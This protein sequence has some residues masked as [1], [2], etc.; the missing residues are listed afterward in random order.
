M[1]DIGDSSSVKR[2][3]S[4]MKIAADV[5]AAYLL[6]KGKVI[7][8]VQCCLDLGLTLFLRRTIKKTEQ[9]QQQRAALVCRNGLAPLKSKL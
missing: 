7:G 5:L 6:L 9:K 2:G 8:G 4:T 1:R 3:Y